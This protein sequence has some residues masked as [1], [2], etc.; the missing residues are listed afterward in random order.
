MEWY[1]K[2]LK[3]FANFNGRSRRKEYWMFILFNII[4]SIVLSILDSLLGLNYG[5]LNTN[6]VLGSLYSLVI[7]IPTFAVTTRRLHDVNKSGWL[8]V[9]L[10][11]TIAVFATIIFTSMSNSDTPNPMIIG[12]IAIVLIGFSIYM[13][14]LSV[15]NGDVGPNKYGP[16]PKGN[17]ELEIEDHLV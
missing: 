6:G 13:F 11:A 2:V 4:I 1:L 5:E 8:L 3:E 9:I 10:Y 7:L 17:G 14:V 16:D 12:I 15:T